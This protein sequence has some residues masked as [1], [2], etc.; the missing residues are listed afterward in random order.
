MEKIRVGERYGR[1]I[2]LE[3][4]HPKDEVLCICD[5][6][7]LKIARATNVY[8]GG[9]KSCGC[10]F[11]EGNNRKHGGKSTRLYLIW[12][13][14][15]ERCNTPSCKGY[16]NYGGRGISVCEEWGNFVVFKE[17]AISNGYN[18]KLSLDRINVN[19]NY[20]PNNCRWATSK[21]QA[22]NKR[23]NHLIT[24]LGETKT[25]TEWA[26]TTGI[27][28]ATIW[29]RLQRGWTVEKTLTQAVK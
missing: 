15:R 12:K 21:E 6:G 16:K 22:N 10:L 4:H 13:A 7:K 29:A 24:Y 27:K 2:V 5:C 11:N 19:G 23:N 28:V 18:D 17:W 26:E 8:H 3:N 20:E 9:T 1:L 25:M 14:M